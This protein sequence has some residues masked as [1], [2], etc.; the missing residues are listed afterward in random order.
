MATIQV[1]M[2][3]HKTKVEVGMESG[4]NDGQGQIK[5]DFRGQQILELEQD[6]YFSACYPS[7]L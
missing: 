1:G 2:T 6:G 3:E 4:V 7:V 5:M